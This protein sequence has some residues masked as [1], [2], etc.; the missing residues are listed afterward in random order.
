M[1]LWSILASPLLAANDVTTMDDLTKSILLNKDVIAVNQDPLGVPGW[2][3]KKLDQ[4]EVWKRPLKGG[5]I[6]VVFVNLDEVPRDIDV[7]WSQLNIDG[8][9]QVT[10]LWEHRSLGEKDEALMFKAIPSHG[11]VF[12]RLSNCR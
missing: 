9:R 10:D 1:S 3:V 4:I 6:A 7:S 12:V 5:D 2:R 8:P 11:V